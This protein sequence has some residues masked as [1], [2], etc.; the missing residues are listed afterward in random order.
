VTALSKVSLLRSSTSDA[1]DVD[2][3]ASTARVE[4]RVDERMLQS[5]CDWER[6]GELRGEREK[7]TKCTVTQ[8]TQSR[9]LSVI[10]R[11]SLAS[12]SPQ[13]DTSRKEWQTSEC[14]PH[15]A[16][17]LHCS[18]PTAPTDHPSSRLSTY[19]ELYGDLYGDPEPT[20]APVPPTTAPVEAAPAPAAPAAPTP[21]A[22][23]YASTPAA[24]SV[25]DTN[26]A[27]QQQPPALHFDAGYSQRAADAN[28]TLNVRPSDMPEEG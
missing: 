6:R 8:S 25:Y 5:R 3:K 17:A 2:A 1:M 21:A 13:F 27:Q 14:Q 9:S 15:T 10:S 20:P 11:Q 12:L 22:A 24:P 28:K 26:P 19:D 16:L 7:A 18:T 23:T 4:R